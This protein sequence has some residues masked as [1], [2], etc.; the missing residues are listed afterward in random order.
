MEYYFISATK[1]PEWL[2]N[3]PLEL[4]VYAPIIEENKQHIRKLNKEFLSTLGG[5]NSK[6]SIRDALTKIR[7]AESLKGF[8][9][10]PREIVGRGFENSGAK[11]EARQLI[12]GAKNCDLIPLKVHQKMFLAGKFVDPFYQDRLSRT[13]IVSADCPMP[14]TTC[15]CNLLG[16][17]P[18]PTTG[19]D[20]NLTV[21]L[22][23]YL[24]EPFTEIGRELIASQPNLLRPARDEEIRERE[25]QREK[26]MKTLEAINPKSCPT[27]LAHAV[28]KMKEV[29]FWQEHA[30]TCVECFGCLMVCPTCFCYLLYDQATD[31]L[32]DQDGVV[33]SPLL[34]SRDSIREGIYNFTRTKIWDACYYAAYARVGGGMNPRAEFLQRFKNRFHCKF[35]NFFLDNNFY[36]CSGCGR[37]LSVCSGKIDI[38][39]I[40]LAVG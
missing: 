39:K 24:L 6:Y 29:T 16:L 22:D 37:C 1:F 4:T 12:I 32:P 30:Q 21:L 35:M 40:L 7:V 9:F 3:L 31:L 34:S 38:R 25:E 15:F 20:I 18:Y 14:E 33:E 23:G 17:A 19:S 27:D 28:E 13:I 5:P 10:V 36:A 26:A 2:A 11:A 8:F